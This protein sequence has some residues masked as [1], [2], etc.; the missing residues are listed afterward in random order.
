MVELTK[1]QARVN[2]GDVSGRFNLPIY[3]RQ[4]LE[5]QTRLKI[6]LLI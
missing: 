3:R 2:A 1:H 6:Y 5:M 4:M